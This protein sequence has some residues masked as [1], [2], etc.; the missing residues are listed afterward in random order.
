MTEA[1]NEMATI[2]RPH[3]TQP[4][5]QPA[6][7]MAGRNGLMF[8]STTIILT[9]SF[10]AWMA[11]VVSE[12]VNDIFSYAAWVMATTLASAFLVELRGGFRNVLRVDL[13]MMFALFIL[14]YFEFLFPQ[15]ALFGKVNVVSAQTS[16]A[17]TVIGFSGIAV[18]RHLLA[19]R[20]AIGQRPNLTFSRRTIMRLM[21]ACFILGY[22]HVLLSVNF[23]VFEA[24][25]QM[26][27]PR[28]SQPWARARLGGIS[29]LLN[30]FGLLKFLLPPIAAVAFYYRRNF[31]FVELI[32]ISIIALI[33]LYESFAGG[34]RNEFLTHVAT[35]SVCYALINKN[36]DLK[37][38]LLIMIPALAIGWFSLTY[39]IEFRKT[40]LV[41]YVEES[42]TFNEVFVDNNM[43]NIAML[44][45]V[46]PD[47]L[48]YLGVEVPYQAL[49]RPIPRGIWQTKPEGLSISIEQA[50]GVGDFMTVSV[51][52]LGE[53]WMAGGFL[54][55]A[56]GSVMVGAI[57]AAWN[58]IGARANSVWD[59]LIFTAG[60]FPAGICMRSLMS[61][62]PP[63][64]PV[65][66]LYFYRR[67]FVDDRTL[68]NA[69]PA[70]R[71]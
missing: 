36:I 35:F 68:Q 5:A 11:A 49:I 54:V 7:N 52:F 31:H 15:Q 28:F 24:L 12:D 43:L 57:S 29:T 40:G 9:G 33:L 44:T 2:D 17:V 30:E 39:M 10:V 64:L 22:L 59:L 70:P 58:R 53:L 27:Q 71:Q 66:A 47:H 26:S 16:V 45:D 1:D 46:F 60:F 69:N 3:P 8:G 19:A 50:L 25:Y 63:M 32:S 56:L 34:T 18:G 13:F 14:T 37:R 38:S 51:T 20:P 23:N 6:A 21:W 4:L 65:I 55:V 67:I 48:G 62:G 41:N 61:A 42:A